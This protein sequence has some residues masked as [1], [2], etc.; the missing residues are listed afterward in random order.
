MAGQNPKK[1]HANS[2]VLNTIKVV[3]DI[4]LRFE[5][6]RDKLI[7]SKNKT[8]YSVEFKTN[9]RL[10]ILLQFLCFVPVVQTVKNNSKLF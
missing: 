10:Q 8:F 6:F 9:M 2:I 4:I 1:V 5:I 3:I 7:N